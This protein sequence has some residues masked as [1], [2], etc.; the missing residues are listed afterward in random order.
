MSTISSPAFWPGPAKG[1]AA[2]GQGARTCLQAGTSERSAAP[3]VSG[4]RQLAHLL[5]E[6]DFRVL[7]R[8]A[9]REVRAGAERA[10][11]ALPA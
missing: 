6:K 4:P 2:N 8:A 5:A 1:E 10:A 9:F 3:T 11:S 7:N